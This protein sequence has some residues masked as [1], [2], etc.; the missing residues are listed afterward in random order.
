MII[1]VIQ[2][3]KMLIVQLDNV[4]IVQ[5]FFVLLDLDNMNIIQLDLDICP[6]VQLDVQCPINII[7]HCS[8]PTLIIAVLK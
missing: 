6:I 7:G 1:F 5:L 8:N 4:Q 2:Y 3:I